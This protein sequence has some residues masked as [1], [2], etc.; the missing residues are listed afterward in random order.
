MSDLQLINGD[1]W[2]YHRDGA[3]VAITTGGLVNKDG[4]CAMPSGTARQAAEKFTTLPYVLGQQIRKYGM[5]VFDLGQRIVSFPVENSPYE[6]PELK[7]IAR[8]CCELVELA[9]YKHWKRI[10]VPRPGCGKGGLSW[11]EVAPLL[12]S[13]FDERFLVITSEGDS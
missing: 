3:V 6:T 1:I 9:N 5:H 10:V 11:Q 13:H 4:H 7:I 2:D 12:A 8:S